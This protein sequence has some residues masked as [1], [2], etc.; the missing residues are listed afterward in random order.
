M[1]KTHNC[2]VNIE[3]TLNLRLPHFVDKTGKT[4]MEVSGR[5]IFAHHGDQTGRICFK[6]NRC[7]ATEG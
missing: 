7:E 5:G 6:Y 1:N 2:V 3:K 4:Y